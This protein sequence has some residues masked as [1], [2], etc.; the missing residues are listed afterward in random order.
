MDEV[1]DIA[2]YVNQLN[3]EEKEWLNSFVEEYVNANFNH[4][5]DRV[6]PV[7]YVEIERKNGT[8][9]MADKHKKQCEDK[10]NARNRCIYTKAKT[11]GNLESYGDSKELEDF[12][13]EKK[14]KNN[15]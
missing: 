7:E 10:N 6:H 1:A 13:T 12:F 11:T 9:Y 3:E 5:K 2:S 14:K 4:G 8:K 15:T